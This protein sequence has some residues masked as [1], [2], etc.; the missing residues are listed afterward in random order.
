MMFKIHSSEE[1]NLYIK[2]KRKCNFAFVVWGFAHGELLEKL[3]A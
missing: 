3:Y 1:F 2:K